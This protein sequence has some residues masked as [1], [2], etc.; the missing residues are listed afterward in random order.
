MSRYLKQTEPSMT[1]AEIREAVRQGL[2]S[3]A[4]KLSNAS[5][6]VIEKPH[7]S[8]FK[9]RPKSVILSKSLPPTERRIRAHLQQATDRLNTLCQQTDEARRL[10]AHLELE[11]KVFQLRCKNGL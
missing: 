10:V 6:P 7:R 2:A 8:G 11:L 4:I 9:P 1:S 3:G 5:A